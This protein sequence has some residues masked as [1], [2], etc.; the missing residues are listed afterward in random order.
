MNLEYLSENTNFYSTQNVRQQCHFQR[1]SKPTQGG[2]RNKV[3]EKNIYS[4]IIPVGA[5]SGKVKDSGRAFGLLF[6]LAKGATHNAKKYC[7][8]L[9]SQKPYRRELR[10]K[11]GAFFKLVYCSC[12]HAIYSVVCNSFIE[13]LAYNHAISSSQASCFAFFGKL[14][15]IRREFQ[16]QSQISCKKHF[17]AFVSLLLTSFRYFL[18]SVAL[19]F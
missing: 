3:Y 5:Y 9:A 2:R 13:M 12:I 14:A 18:L 16:S 11:K 19:V 6:L 7:L 15:K 8:F 17:Y 4:C 10:Y 1:L